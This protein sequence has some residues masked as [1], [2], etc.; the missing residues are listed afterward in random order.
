MRIFLG[1]ESIAGVEWELRKGLSKLGVDAQVVLNYSNTFSYPADEIYGGTNFFRRRLSGFLN[2][3]RFVK[4]FDTFIFS[5]DVTILPF[6][7]DIPL[8]KFKNKKLIMIFHG[9]EIRCNPLVLNNQLDKSEC[10]YCWNKCNIEKKINRA[11]YWGQNGDLI[12]VGVSKTA[13]FDHFSIPYEL[14]I[15]PCDLSHWKPFHKNV[16]KDEN[17]LLII[18]AP[19][20]KKTKGTSHITKAISN[21]KSKYDFE[22]KLIENMANNEVRDWINSADIVI[23]QIARGWY[24]MFSIESMA[25]EKPT[26]CYIDPIFLREFP[27]FSELP[28]HNI[29][30]SN[31]ENRIEEL[32]I[33]PD[34]RKE[35]GK[36]GRTYVEN[37]HDSEKVCKNVYDTLI[38]IHK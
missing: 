34:L 32:I 16:K 15:L 31:I 13:L 9:S 28:L 20:N 5:F 24:G 12:F 23:D 14:L 1:P 38:K 33:S 4:E 2:I 8:L 35:L 30:P 10:S 18:H 26:C 25:M 27:Q 7:L 22:F 19:S 6:R 21:L 37:I 36:K 11:K 29:N 17:K 3:K